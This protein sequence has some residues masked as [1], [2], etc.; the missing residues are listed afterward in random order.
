MNTNLLLEA[1]WASHSFVTRKKKHFRFS[2]L[3]DEISMKIL[4]EN[5]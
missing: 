5:N 4:D 1:I 2:F 3:S